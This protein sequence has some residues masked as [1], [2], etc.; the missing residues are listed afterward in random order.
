MPHKYLLLFGTLLFLALGETVETVA[1]AT[2]S[3][4]PVASFIGPYA[5]RKPIKAQ[6]KRKKT[7][8]RHN[9]P[10]NRTIY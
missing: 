8:V 7:K 3:A 2:G 10:L 5:K 4:T 6:Y 1:A 9:R